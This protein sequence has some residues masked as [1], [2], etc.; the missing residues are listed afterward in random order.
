MANRTLAQL[1]LCDVVV[2][3]LRDNQVIHRLPLLNPIRNGKHDIMLTILI[4]RHPL[5]TIKSLHT[6][7]IL[8]RISDRTPTMLHTWDEEEAV[9]G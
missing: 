3:E 6:T 4:P 1:A 9:K 7:H 5:H 2:L 8:R